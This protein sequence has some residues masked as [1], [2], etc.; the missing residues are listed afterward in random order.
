MGRATVEWAGRRSKWWLREIR[1]LKISPQAVDTG[2]MVRDSTRAVELAL[3][4]LMALGF[5]GA[6]NAAGGD[7]NVEPNVEG[8]TTGSP[9]MGSA[10]TGSAMTGDPPKTACERIAGSVRD[11]GLLG[12]GETGCD[13]VEE[14]T[15]LMMCFADCYAS[16]SC[17]EIRSVF[18]FGDLSLGLDNCIISC[19]AASPQFTCGDGHTIADIRVCDTTRDCVDGSDE[20]ACPTFVC[21]D[22][23]TI[24]EVWLCDFLSDCED[25]SD[26]ANCVDPMFTC[27]DG[28]MIPEN[29]FCDDEADCEDGSDEV[30]CPDL[31]ALVCQ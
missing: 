12:M 16:T 13:A 26:E 4:S 8:P 2:Q 11:C 7:G 6:C 5:T 20:A 30:G 28:E 17:A 24:P 18:C 31:A 19:E 27:G 15:E 9:T 14:T 25:G 29:W 21:D 22:G 10:T 23:G 1:L 3:R